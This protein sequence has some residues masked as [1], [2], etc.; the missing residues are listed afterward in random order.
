MTRRDDLLDKLERAARE[1][2]HE[3]AH[4]RKQNSTDAR[5]DLAHLRQKVSELDNV[6][7]ELARFEAATGPA[8]GSDHALTER[9]QARFEH[10]PGKRSAV[11]E[12]IAE[13]RLEFWREEREFYDH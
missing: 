5:R 12:L 2:E 13:R 6:L 4:L 11:D 1:I 9:I 7:L 10:L 8:E 3:V